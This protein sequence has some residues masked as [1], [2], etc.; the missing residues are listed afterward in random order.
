L[1]GRET[2]EEFT[3][4]IEPDHGGMIAAAATANKRRSLAR[5]GSPASNGR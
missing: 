3:D 4:V 2:V 5:A 1:R